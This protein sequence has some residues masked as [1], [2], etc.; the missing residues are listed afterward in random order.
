MSKINITQLG[1]W[2][3]GKYYIEGLEYEF[4]KKPPNKDIVG[5]GNPRIKQKWKRFLWYE[6]YGTFSP[7]ELNELSE[8]E[9]STLKK[10]LKEEVDRIKDG[11]WIY[12]N[13]E[14]T[15]LN[16]MMYFFLQWFILED[17]GE[18]PDYRDTSLYYYR[19]IEITEKTKLC[20][21][22]TLIKGRRLGATSMVM[23]RILRNML[24]VENK[25]FGITSKGGED[26]EGAFS[27]LVTA[28]INLPPF[29]KP[30]I[31]G[32][33]RP[34]KTLSMRQQAS[35]VRKGQQ[36]TSTGGGLNNSCTWRATG[37]NTFDSGAY[38]LI[39]VD[40]SGKFSRDVP[41]SKYI[42][43]VTKCVK[44]GARVTGKLTLPTTVNPPHEGGE[45]YRII[46]EGS[47]QSKA[48][49]LGQT[50]TGL[51]RI[52]IPAYF[53]F[54]GYIGEFGE[55][56]VENPTPEQTKYLESLGG[57]CPDPTIG[58]KQYLELVRKNLESNPEDLMEEIR[59]NP[60][61]AEEVF[62]SSNNRCIFNVDNL[63]RRIRELEDKLVEQGMNPTKDELGRRGWFR[64]K[65]NGKVV[66]EDDPKGLW[67]IHYLL[68]EIH[69]N[70]RRQIGIDK[71]GN[72]KFV[73]LNES[74]G[75]A[76]LDPVASGQS[77]VEKGSD[78]S[79]IIRRRYVETDEENSDIP[80]AMFLGRMEDIDDMYEQ[81]FNGL[82]YYGVKML[83]ERA[84]D[85]FVTFAEKR[86]L[87]GYLYGTKRSDGSEVKGI[88][89]QQSKSVKDNHAR[90]Q[91][92]KSLDDHHK[93]PFITLL[94][95]RLGF[96]IDKRTEWDTCMADGYA[97]MAEEFDVKKQEK[98]VKKIKVIRRKHISYI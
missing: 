6:K 95:H 40:E 97:I 47:D 67:Y 53:G 75:T 78:A 21:G 71:N 73:P 14:P 46:W 94:R 83:G 68:P 36:I 23:A 70:K 7:E 58:A 63:N 19:F 82:I 35:R 72:Y 43:I 26:A 91:V 30:Q 3:D 49:Y 93:I 50:K 17:T 85:Y 32:N 87:S 28:F 11:V 33:D 13:G 20:T 48:D 25:R 31:E 69:S 41:V 60:F 24:L 12:I 57:D 29:L 39:L 92:T 76:G 90:V 38:E 44:K 51:Y 64:K 86:G 1:E 81:M 45:E 55:S 96:S 56:I 37:L 15:Y 42:P 62:D 54:D 18:Y 65:S 9:L 52:T 89:S 27:I 74:F 84:P 34:K 79:L 80:V 2:K 98:E 4:P 8:E 16:G 88:V 61:N 10:E 5:Y 22:D 77:T 66:F 59:M